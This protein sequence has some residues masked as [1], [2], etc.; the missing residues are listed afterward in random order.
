MTTWRDGLLDDL[1]E[2]DWIEDVVAQLQRAAY[3]KP[4]AGKRGMSGWQRLPE[5]GRAILNERDRNIAV[6]WNEEVHKWMIRTLFLN[7]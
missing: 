4:E 1:D 6:S 2:P 7:Y 5:D 3:L